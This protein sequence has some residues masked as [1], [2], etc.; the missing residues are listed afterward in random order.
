VRR[1]PVDCLF[2]RTHAG[3]PLRGQL[4]RALHRCLPRT[5]NFPPIAFE[6]RN[7]PSTTN[8][9]GLKGAG[10]AGTIGSTPAVI[11]G[12]PMASLIHA[13]PQRPRPTEYG[14]AGSS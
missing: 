1:F 6:T 3:P 5:D 9:M 12:A 2:G 8:P 14:C 7:V 4:L 11:K 10:E 13:R